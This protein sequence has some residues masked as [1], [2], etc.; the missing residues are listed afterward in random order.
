M[1]WSLMVDQLLLLLLLLH[2][3]EANH[4]CG[5]KIAHWG[6]FLVPVVLAW[7]RYSSKR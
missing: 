7:H 1:F 5:R 4:E 2:T 6:L 3:V